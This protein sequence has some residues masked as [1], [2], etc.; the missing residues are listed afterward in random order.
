MLASCSD[1]CAILALCK[2]LTSSHTSRASSSVMPSAGISSRGWPATSSMVSSTD[3]SSAFDDPARQITGAR[4]RGR[5]SLVCSRG[6]EPHL[7]ERALVDRRSRRATDWGWLG[8]PMVRHPR[9]PPAHAS[10]ISGRPS[11]AM[12][13]RAGSAER[14][15]SPRQSISSACLQNPYPSRT[16]R[17][18]R[19]CG[20]LA[21]T[22]ERPRPPAVWTSMMIGR[23]PSADVSHPRSVVR[24]GGW[25]TAGRRG[26]RRAR[27]TRCR[28]RRRFAWS[29][30]SSGLCGRC[31][32]SAD[33]HRCRVRRPGSAI[34][35]LA[36]LS[37]SSPAY[38]C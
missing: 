35:W 26:C 28:A 21:R 23:V 16:N 1:R 13:R 32:G 30:G 20:S 9:Q 18:E 7:P 11:R 15:C 5:H 25:E 17:Q 6:A 38:V 8:N 14:G 19:D 22:C 29:A 36:P 3:P 12:T 34:K 2:R 31:R 33:G 10:H 24:R 4:T 37:A 27:L